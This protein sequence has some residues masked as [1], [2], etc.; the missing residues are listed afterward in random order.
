MKLLAALALALAA[1]SKG[2]SDCERAVHHVLFDLTSPRGAPAPSS[3]EQDVMRQVEA[4]TVPVCEKEGLEPAQ[5]A[6]I[7]AAHSAEDFAAMLRC[8]AI[9][10]RRPSWLIGG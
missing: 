7:L 8:P 10:A 2:P 5:L 1:C 9:A 4:T 3:D 6:C